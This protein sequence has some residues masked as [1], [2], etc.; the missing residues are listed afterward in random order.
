MESRRR[1]KAPIRTQRA[2]L[3]LQHVTQTGRIHKVGQDHREEHF[4][5]LCSP[6]NALQGHEMH[7]VV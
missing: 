1:V 4:G 5:I 7:P 2:L 6:I 3:C